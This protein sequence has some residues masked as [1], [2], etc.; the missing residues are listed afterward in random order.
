MF[1]ASLDDVA[2]GRTFTMPVDDAATSKL[3]M[4]LFF[5]T[6]DARAEH[7]RLLAAGVEVD[8]EPVEQPYGIDFGLRDPFGNHVRIAQ[9]SAPPA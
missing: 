6:D 1:Q 3:P 7:A 5:A 9:M 4:I 2:D 8:P